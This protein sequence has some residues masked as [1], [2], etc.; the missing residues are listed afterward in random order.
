VPSANL[1]AGRNHAL[2][3][4]RRGHRRPDHGGRNLAHS[5]S[6]GDLPDSD[7]SAGGDRDADWGSA[8]PR[9]R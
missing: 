8:R 7:R 9:P 6:G 5:T 4:F 2:P 1:L 3:L